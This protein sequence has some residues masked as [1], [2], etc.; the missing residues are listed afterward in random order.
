M[1]ACVRACV[2]TWTRRR[3]KAALSGSASVT[4]RG[5]SMRFDSCRT[6][7]YAWVG[8]GVVWPSWIRFVNHKTPQQNLSY[9]STVTATVVPPLPYLQHQLAVGGE[10]DGLRRPHPR[11]HVRERACVIGGVWM[12]DDQ[13]SRLID[14]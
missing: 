13:F 9:T 5:G 8:G 10:D 12:T 1:R 3:V 2:P 6:Q 11:V 4:S 14:E 7:S